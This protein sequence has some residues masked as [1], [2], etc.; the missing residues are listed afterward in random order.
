MFVMLL[1]FV[2]VAAAII[3][4]SQ[5]VKGIE[6]KNFGS[7]FLAALLLGVANA[8]IRPILMFLTAPINW[9]TFGLFALVVNGVLLKLVAEFLE[10]FKVRTWMAAILGALL[11]SIV[12]S[13]MRAILL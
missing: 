3:L 7:A 11:I 10:G 2:I 8:L 1:H 9:M 5:V 12:S 4:V 6:V 13:I